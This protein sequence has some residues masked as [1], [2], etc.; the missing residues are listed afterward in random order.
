MRLLLTPSVTHEYWTVIF[1]RGKFEKWINE[2]QFNYNIYGNKHIFFRM[3]SIERELTKLQTMVPNLKN[4][5][6]EMVRR[7]LIANTLLRIKIRNFFCL[8]NSDQNFSKKIS[9][10]DAL[11]K[12]KSFWTRQV[13]SLVWTIVFPLTRGRFECE[14]KI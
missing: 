6:N 4:K 8:S 12:S 14:S 7:I 13:N 3:T 2:T 9:K 11:Y 5:Q 10:Q 1:W